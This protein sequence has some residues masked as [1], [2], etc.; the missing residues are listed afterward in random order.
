MVRDDLP[1]RCWGAWSVEGFLL[2]RRDEKIDPTEEVTWEATWE[3][4]SE[5]TLGVTS[6]LWK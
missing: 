5:P 6:E 2:G 3:L 4:T 1:I